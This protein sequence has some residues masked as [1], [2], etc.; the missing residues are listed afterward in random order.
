MDETIDPIYS[1][2]LWPFPVDLWPITVLIKQDERAAKV[3]VRSK[4][5]DLQV[6]HCVDLQGGCAGVTI[7]AAIHGISG[8]V[9]YAIVYN[10]NTGDTYRIDHNYGG[11]ASI[12]Y[13]DCDQGKQPGSWDVEDAGS[14]VVYL[15]N[16]KQRRYRLSPVA[17]DHVRWVKIKQIELAPEPA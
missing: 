2:N 5:K 14:G 7:K 9:D 15:R 13:I 17:D 8:L 4:D 16:N 6:T 12:H 11:V 3:I 10:K 1:G